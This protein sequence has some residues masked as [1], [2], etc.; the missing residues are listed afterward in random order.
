MPVHQA[1]WEFG[2][3]CRVC[4]AWC[5]AHRRCQKLVALRILV[6][7]PRL[8]VPHAVTWPAKVTQ[9]V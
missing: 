8:G 2:A 7:N 5:L 1:G 4:L 6:P 3:S 9:I